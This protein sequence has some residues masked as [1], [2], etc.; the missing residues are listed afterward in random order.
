MDVRNILTMLEDTYNSICIFET[1]LDAALS[2]DRLDAPPRFYFGA[3]ALP[4]LWQTRFGHVQ[5]WPPTPQTLHTF[6]GFKDRLILRSVELHSPGFWEVFGSLNPLESMRKWLGDAHERRK[7]R[8]YREPAEKERL[9]LENRLLET[10]L[11]NKQI[12]LMKSVGATADD[13]APFRNV[14]LIDPLIK[15]ERLQNQGL[16]NGA[17]EIRK[18]D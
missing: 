1:L 13:L 12:E 17:D 2:Y 14:L 15:L 11:M 8:E 7:D 3:A 5:T 6:V 16:L 18:G 9:D 4:I 10:E